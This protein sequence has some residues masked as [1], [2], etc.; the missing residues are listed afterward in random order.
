MYYARTKT[1]Q[2]SWTKK[3]SKTRKNIFFEIFNIFKQFCVRCAP[4]RA[5]QKKWPLAIGKTFNN[6]KLVILMCLLNCDSLWLIYSGNIDIDL[7]SIFRFHLF[8]NKVSLSSIYLKVTSLM[9]VPQAF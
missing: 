9:A 3:I 8:C 4:I 1:I 2:I 5:L 7:H 6:Y